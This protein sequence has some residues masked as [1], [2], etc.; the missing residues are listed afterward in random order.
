M[1]YQYYMQHIQQ[2][3]AM[4]VYIAPANYAPLAYMPIQNL[5]PAMPMPRNEI[6]VV[7]SESDEEDDVDQRTLFCANLSEHVT[8]EILYEV[9]FQA[10]PLSKVHIPKQ[11]GKNRSYGF[12][13]YKYRCSV[14][15]AL[16]L[17]QGLVLFGKRLDIKFQGK[18]N[19]NAYNMR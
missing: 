14:P 17:Y 18:H 9:F 7:E 12:V 5:E 10:G 1:S 8:E 4:G 15:Y 3:M 13:T 2:L 11:N 6:V 19:S 16:K